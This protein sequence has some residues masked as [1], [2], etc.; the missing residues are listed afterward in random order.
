MDNHN[1]QKS[2]HWNIIILLQ[3]SI[4]NIFSRYFDITTI[5]RTQIPTNLSHEIHQD[6]N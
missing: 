6:E 5:P 4:P 3:L 2:D 1:N